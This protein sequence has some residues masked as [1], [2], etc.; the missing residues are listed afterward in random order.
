LDNISISLLFD[1]FTL[2]TNLTKKLESKDIADFTNGNSAFYIPV[3]KVEKYPWNIEGKDVEEP[4]V[5]DDLKE[6]ISICKKT[7]PTRLKNET[8]FSLIKKCN[9]AVKYLSDKYPLEK[10]FVNKNA[11]QEDDRNQLLE[12]LEDD[13]DSLGDMLYDNSEIILNLGQKQSLDVDK[14][15]LKILDKSAKADLGEGLSLLHSGHTTASY[16][17]LMRVAEFLV[18]QYFFK[19]AGRK[20][21]GKEQ[22]WGGMLHTIEQL[23]YDSKIDKTFGKLLDFLKDRRNEASHPGKRFDEK[24]CKKL[25]SYVEDLIEFF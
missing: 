13:W 21:I 11:L 5:I 18:Q 23:G 22:S 16:M 4:G 15:S 7:K 3:N 14:K 12:G 8:I 24:D 6:I 9:G 19:K 17:I 20:A 1:V 10:R 2:V 25:I